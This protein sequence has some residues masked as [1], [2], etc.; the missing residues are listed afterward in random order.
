MLGTVNSGENFKTQFKCNTSCAPYQILINSFFSFWESHFISQDSMI[1]NMQKSTT[2]WDWV[3]NHFNESHFTSCA[4]RYAR[5][6]EI[7]WGIIQHDVTKFIGH[8]IAVI[9][10][11]ELGIGTKDTL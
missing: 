4:P 2:F 6:L 5:S 9:I 11:C 10:L 3:H 1:E 8:Y 7:K